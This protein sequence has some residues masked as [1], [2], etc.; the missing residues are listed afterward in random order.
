LAARYLAIF[1]ETLVLSIFEKTYLISLPALLCAPL[2]CHAGGGYLAEDDINPDPSLHSTWTFSSQAANWAFQDS[3]GSSYY[4]V[5]DNPKSILVVFLPGTGSTPG[6]Y[7][8]FLQNAGGANGSDAPDTRF[9]TL[10]IAYIN[11]TSLKPLGRHCTDDFPFQSNDQHNDCLWQTRGEIAFGHQVTAPGVTYEPSAKTASPH[12]SWNYFDA[13]QWTNSQYPQVLIQDSIVSRLIFAID[14]M[15]WQTSTYDP[16]WGA[17]LIDDSSSPYVAP[18][19]LPTGSPAG[20]QRSYQYTRHVKLDWSKI[21][22]AGHSQGGGEAAFMAMNVPVAVRRVALFSA[23]QDN[24]DGNVVQSTYT[25][26]SA[27]KWIGNTTA[28]PLASFWGLRNASNNPSSSNNNTESWYGNNVWNNLQFIG[29]DTDTN[30][31]GGTGRSSP[32]D[33]GDG[34]ASSGNSQNLFLD[35][36]N[37]VY[38]INAHN[39]TAANGADVAPA[40][41][42]IWGTMLKGGSAD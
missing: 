2:I 5:P 17:F 21:I 42:T 9:Y 18:H 8:D 41:Y 6:N 1:Q 39:S 7:T 12:F 40:V 27:A 32:T 28:T 20:S 30:G 31:L 29:H 15:T 10:G 38:A 11:G 26:S 25:P 34:T 22:L 3:A 16:G 23:P 14:A 36:P 37:T 35:N 13:G 19:N 24:V 4:Y 33:V